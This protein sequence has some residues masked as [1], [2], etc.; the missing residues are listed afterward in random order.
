MQQ[1]R[2]QI[3]STAPVAARGATPA[4]RRTR[5]SPMAVKQPRSQKVGSTRRPKRVAMETQRSPKRR[6][7]ENLSNAGRRRSAPRRLVFASRRCCR[8][9]NLLNAC[10][11][12]IT[13]AVAQGLHRH[14]DHPG[15]ARCQGPGAVHAQGGAGQFGPPVSHMGREGGGAPKPSARRKRHWDTCPWTYL[16]SSAVA[17][18]QSRGS[19]RPIA[20]RSLALIDLAFLAMV[21]KLGLDST[22]RAAPA[23]QK[24]SPISSWTFRGDGPKPT[25]SCGG[26]PKSSAKNASM[27]EAIFPL[28]ADSRLERKLNR[29]TELRQQQRPE[30]SAIKKG[31]QFTKEKLLFFLWKP[32]GLGAPPS[33]LGAGGIPLRVVPQSPLREQDQRLVRRWCRR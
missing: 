18:P 13:K 11:G 10:K 24:S 33:G 17:A 4:K 9:E 5:T 16:A 29:K 20:A 27:C 32:D 26:V 19:P 21:Y 7:V 31:G 23:V 6:R 22:P 8:V 25:F 2:L 3:T 30:A 1:K 12:V 14:A 15:H 28:A